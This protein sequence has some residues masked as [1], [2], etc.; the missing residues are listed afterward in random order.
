MGSSPLQT[1]RAVPALSHVRI[2]SHAFV[3]GLIV[4]AFME[5]HPRAPEPEVAVLARLA[6]EMVYTA[7]EM[8]FDDA[9]LDDRAV[10][11]AL[12]EMLA[13]R[14]TALRRQAQ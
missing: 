6:V 12:S 14:M 8:L 5:A 10:G 7:M 2:E 1:L 9:S 4:T 13:Q 11:E 3:S